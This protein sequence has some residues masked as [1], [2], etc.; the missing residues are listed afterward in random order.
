[1]HV[2]AIL[3]PL[4]AKWRMRASRLVPTTILSAPLL[5]DDLSA[6]HA[7]SLPHSA[8]HKRLEAVFEVQTKSC[9]FHVVANKQCLPVLFQRHKILS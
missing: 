4:P 3:P 1:M 7:P 5:A 2:V 9:S 6:P 8:R